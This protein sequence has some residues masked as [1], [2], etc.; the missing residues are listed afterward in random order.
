VYDAAYGGGRTAERT[1]S[2]LAA[3]GVPVLVPAPGDT[4]PTGGRATVVALHPPRDATGLARNLNDVSLVVR[5]EDGPLS[6]L[7]AGDLEEPGERV[8]LAAGRPLASDGLQV[9]HHGSDTSTGA[10]FLAA[11][12]PG[13]AVVSVGR[14]NRYGHP[15]PVTLAR[16]RASGIRVHRTDRDGAVWVV[17]RGDTLRF[18]L[19]PPR[20][21]GSVVPP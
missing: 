8:L 7:F 9:G 19:H 17:A 2:L 16:L 1:R 12:D 18:R 4:L 21:A 20:R 10:S 6:V 5:I 14:D 3:H 11:V 13:W 15:D